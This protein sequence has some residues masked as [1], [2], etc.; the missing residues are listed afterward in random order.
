MNQG[1]NPRLVKELARLVRAFEPADFETL[2]GALQSEE[3]RQGLLRVLGTMAEGSRTLSRRGPQ[4]RKG[5]GSER[6]RLPALIEGLRGSDPE[7][8]ELLNELRLQLSRKKLLSTPRQ[9]IEFC[10][11]VGLTVGEQVTRGEAVARLIEYLATQPLE[12]IK[13]FTA[14][15][16]DRNSGRLQGGQ[17]QAWADV[18]MRRTS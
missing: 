9:V 15:L 8:F 1:V 6:R 18:I 10:R 4:A 12:S 2:M 7:R 17:L 14:G 5:G 16:R 3:S 11:E 13:Q